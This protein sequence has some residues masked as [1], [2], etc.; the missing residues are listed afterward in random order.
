MMPFRV[1]NHDESMID[2]RCTHDLFLSRVMTQTTDRETNRPVPSSVTAPQN[3]TKLI[4]SWAS[5]HACS[6]SNEVFRC[7]LGPQGR[8]SI[9]LVKTFGTFR[10]GG[11]DGSKVRIQTTGPALWNVTRPGK[12]NFHSRFSKRILC[13]RFPRHYMDLLHETNVQKTC[14]GRLPDPRVWFSWHQCGID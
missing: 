10:E 7:T 9:L 1:I 5:I 6:S 3:E 4:D 2:S 12:R 8:R 13:F 11:H 14:S